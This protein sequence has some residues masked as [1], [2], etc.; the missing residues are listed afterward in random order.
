MK[1][2]GIDREPTVIDFQ[3]RAMGS[4][5]LSEGERLGG[6]RQGALAIYGGAHF[7]V[8]MEELFT[9]LHS[10]MFYGPTFLKNFESHE[11]WGLALT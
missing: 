4:T 6:T 9:K 10:D 11:A 8:D 3:R 1:D 2:W 7:I 5:A